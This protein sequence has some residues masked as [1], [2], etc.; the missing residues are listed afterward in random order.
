MLH[1]AIA[2]HAAVSFLHAPPMATQPSFIE[3]GYSEFAE[4]SLENNTQRNAIV[5]HGAFDGGDRLGSA[6]DL[7]ELTPAC[8]HV[9]EPTDNTV[10]DGA[11]DLQDVELVHNDDEEPV[12]EV[13]LSVLAKNLAGT[14]YMSQRARYPMWS[15]FCPTDPSLGWEERGKSI[16]VDCLICHAQRYVFLCS[17]SLVFVPTRPEV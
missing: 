11:P 6:G 13:L 15:F 10:P 3:V 8:E 1:G 14:W 16:S 9:V 4:N 7:V 12:N 17:T 2:R 5:L